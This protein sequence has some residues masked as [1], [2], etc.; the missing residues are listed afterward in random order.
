MKYLRLPGFRIYPMPL[1][2]FMLCIILA[3]DLIA[4]PSFRLPLM[5]EYIVLRPARWEDGRS[6]LEVEEKRN[7][8]GLVFIYY[9]N[10]SDQAV[11]LSE[12]YLND[13][14]SGQYRLAGDIA[15][16]RR[17][18]TVVQ[19]GETSVLEICGVSEDFSPG[20]PVIFSQLNRSN[21]NVT[22]HE[23]VFQKEQVHISSIIF[24]SDLKQLTVHLQNHTDRRVDIQDIIFSGK[25]VENLWVSSE[26]IE[27]GGHVVAKVGLTKAYSHGDLA[28][29]Q[30]NLSFEDSFFSIYSHRNAYGDFFPNGTWGLHK[31]QFADARRHHLD[32]FVTGL[33]SEDDFFTKDYRTT[34]FKAMPYTGMLPDIDMLRELESHEAVAGWHI[35]D[36]RERM[37]HPQRIMAVS[38]MTKKYSVNKPTFI[39]LCRNMKFFEYAYL[40]DIPCQAH[41]SLTAAS[42]TSLTDPLGTRLEES[43]Y[44]TRDLKYASAPRP[45]WVWSQ[46]LHLWDEGSKK[47]VPTPEELGAQFYYNLGRGAKGNLWF[48]F[49]EEAGNM[50]PETKKAL[51]IY[52]RV[53]STL[54]E[55]L[56]IADPLHGD[57]KSPEHLDVA[58]LISPDKTILF[59]SNNQYHI[60]DSACLWTPLRNIDIEVQLPAWFKATNAYEFNP[61]TGFQ[62][63][64]WRQ[65]KNTLHLHFKTIDM[66]AVV[67]VLTDRKQKEI[68]IEKFHQALAREQ[69]Q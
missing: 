22:Y 37:Y 59:L 64:K 17:Y 26:I 54:K 65:S 63:L 68:L 25:R 2:V 51:Q 3:D 23:S 27:P 14:E 47:K 32:T 44:Y 11:S 56:L 9:T 18:N 16:D 12:W 69:V 5:V 36:E 46:G 55:D 35:H 20:R 50:Y 67:V 41:Y 21:R 8:G 31:L 30:C 4:D 19:P 45:F 48:A 15:W 58:P 52:S 29:I 13:R 39:T 10:V 6:N 7:H 1:W 66:G 40:A 53:V 24:E 57:Q 61:E 62:M 43:A 34:G 49:H 38:E 33:A 42:E 28:I 60:T